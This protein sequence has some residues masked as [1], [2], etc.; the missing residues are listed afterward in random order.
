[1]QHYQRAIA[2]SKC[3]LLLTGL[4]NCDPSAAEIK[5]EFTD[6]PD[7]A[8]STHQVTQRP[9]RYGSEPAFVTSLFKHPA[10]PLQ[11]Q[12][13]LNTLVTDTEIA[14]MELQ[15]RGFLLQHFICSSC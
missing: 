1:V 4:G 7:V 2:R 3:C 5:E 12:Q 13:L 6:G 10:N 8:P 9:F 15:V 11:V 14:E